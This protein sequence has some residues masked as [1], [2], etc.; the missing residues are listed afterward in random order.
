MPSRSSINTAIYLGTTVVSSL[1]GLGTALLMTHLLAPAQFGQVGVFFSLLYI[2]VPLVSLA[3]DGLIGVFKT[4]LDQE[5]YEQF[6]RTALGI[7]LIVFGVQLCVGTLA[8][9][10]GFVREPVLLIV[11][12]FALLRFCSS[13]AATEYIAEQ[14]AA[15][16]SALTLLNNLVALFLTYALMTWVSPTAL[17]RIIALMVA[18]FMVLMVRYHGRMHLLLRPRIDSKYRSQILSYGI[19]SLVALLGAWGL[20]ES[21]KIVVAKGFGLAVTGL[22]TA[23]A[24]LVSVM[25]SFNQSLTN[26]LYPGLFARLA[27]RRHHL[28]TLM[29]EYFLKFVGINAC[30]AAVVIA[31]YILVKDAL[32]PVKYANASIYFYALVLGSLGIAAYRPFGLIAEYFR[33]G[34]VR[35]IAIVSGGA[36]TMTVSFFGTKYFGSPVWAAVG[37]GSGYMLT[38]IILLLFLIRLE[39]DLEPRPHT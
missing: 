16:Y 30:F 17:S 5:E 12:A 15:V 19:P 4:T 36:C 33:M 32:L 28:K 38:A 29:L 39:Y 7:A 20:N 9:L 34:R 31:G 22:Y 6:R 25:M 35:A 13:M 3:A 1:L 11:P 37:I 26:A 18:E 14:R 10:A 23:A 21:D 24:T 2:A 8:W 27:Q